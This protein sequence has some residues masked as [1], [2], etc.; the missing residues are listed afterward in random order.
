[1]K[2]LGSFALMW[3]PLPAPRS[4]RRYAWTGLIVYLGGAMRN[5]N[6]CVTCGVPAQGARAH[7]MRFW[8]V[9]W[10]WTRVSQR[11][12]RAGDRRHI[13]RRHRI[14]RKTF[15]RNGTRLLSRMVNVFRC[16]D[17]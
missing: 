7:V 6:V 1:M 10:N 4:G 5:I 15:T 3:P 8:S 14:H 9:V 11:R 13:R 2:T 17:S 16:E 12:R